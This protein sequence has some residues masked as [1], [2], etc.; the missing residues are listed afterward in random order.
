MEWIRSFDDVP[1][2][3]KSKTLKYIEMRQKG[4]PGCLDRLVRRVV[5]ILLNTHE[6]QFSVTS[7]DIPALK[8]SRNSEDRELFAR[9]LLV[10]DRITESDEYDEFLNSII[11]EAMDGLISTLKSPH[12]RSDVEM[13]LIPIV[14]IR[15]TNVTI[16]FTC[17]KI[18]ASYKMPVP[19]HFR[20]LSIWEKYKDAF[21]IS[22]DEKKFDVCFMFDNLSRPITVTMS[23]NP[24]L[25]I[26]D[27]ELQTVA[28]RDLLLSLL[29]LLF[30]GNYVAR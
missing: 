13:P 28:S 22:K 9:E 4:G 8:E 2:A 7:A 10:S 16:T 25:T 18:K 30:Q 11:D 3:R 21:I 1:P 19:N 14:K 20:L 29:V 26:R 24:F 15:P 17:M 12:H 6:P 27:I 23:S 5:N